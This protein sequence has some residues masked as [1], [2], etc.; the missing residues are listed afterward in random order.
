MSS[1][2]TDKELPSVSFE[3][4]I[5]AEINKNV[6]KPSKVFGLKSGVYTDLLRLFIKR[7]FL[8]LF[9]LDFFLTIFSLKSVVILCWCKTNHKIFQQVLVLGRYCAK[10]PINT[11]SFN[12]FGLC[13]RQW[14]YSY[15]YYYYFFWNN[16][17][18]T[19][20]TLLVKLRKVNQLKICNTK[21]DHYLKID[22]YNTYVCIYIMM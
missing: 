2:V 3:P 8:A 4:L 5:F 22:L 12:Y 17:D 6:V 20:K 13:Q 21:P 14:L 1:Y 15:Y 11:I 7:D 18:E 10:P 9:F 19:Y 16:V